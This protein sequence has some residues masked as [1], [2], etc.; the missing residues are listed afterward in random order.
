MFIAAFF[1]P[2]ATY[3]EC[4]IVASNSVPADRALTP[5]VGSFP[6]EMQ[7]LSSMERLGLDDFEIKGSIDGPFRTWAELIR[8]HVGR[9]QLTG[10]IPEDIASSSPKLNDLRLSSN[11]LTGTIPSGISNLVLTSLRLSNNFFSGS[12]PDNFGAVNFTTLGTTIGFVPF[13]DMT[14]TI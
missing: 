9:N 11:G 4:V 5:L 2:T 8:F 13:S 6:L 3:I 10:K 1:R 7:Y 14:L 12:L